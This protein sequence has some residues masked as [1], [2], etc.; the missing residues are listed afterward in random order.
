MK[1]SPMTA[2]GAERLRAELEKLKSKDRP[3]V[4]AAIAEARAHGDLRENAE[5]HAA[6]EQQGFI[7]GRINELDALTASNT[8]MIKDEGGSAQQGIQLVSAKTNEAGGLQ[9]TAQNLGASLGT[10][11]IGSVLIAALTTGFVARVE[12]NP[13][14]PADVRD[15][16]AQVAEKGIPVVP[17]ADVEQAV[18]DAGV[19]PGQAKAIADDYGDAQLDGL[20]RAIGAV[21]VFA[22]LSLWFTRRLPSRATPARG[23]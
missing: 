8:K 11:L 12:Q 22:L 7:E 3:R 21:A 9:G 17:V 6:R 4:I 15:R 1:R 18:V 16:L 19:P 20:K 13:A 2:K 10:A 23:A 5:Y 14:I